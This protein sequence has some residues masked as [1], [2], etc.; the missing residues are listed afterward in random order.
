MFPQGGNL[1][2]SEAKYDILIRERNDDSKKMTVIDRIEL[3]P[4]PCPSRAFRQLRLTG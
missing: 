2:R 4:F 3:V 1:P